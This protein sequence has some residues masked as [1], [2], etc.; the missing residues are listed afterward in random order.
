LPRFWPQKPLTLGL[1][2]SGGAHLLLEVNQG[3][4]CFD[5]YKVMVDSVRKQL[6]SDRVPYQ[7]LRAGPQGI[8]LSYALDDLPSLEKTFLTFKGMFN[9][10]YAPQTNGRGICRLSLTEAEGKALV[11]QALEKSIETIR[12]RIDETGTKEPII[13]P[14]GD[15]RILL[16]VPGA[17]KPE[18]IKSRIKTRAY[19]TFQLV[20]RTIPSEDRASVVLKPHEEVF[21][22]STKKGDKPR[23]FYIVN[24]ETIAGGEM[25]VG[26]RPGFGQY[27]DPI[28]EFQF[29][30]LGGRRFGEATSQNIGRPL[31]IVLD[32]E[33][34]SAP[35]INATIT[36]RG[37]IQG[38]FTVQEAQELSLLMR[39]GALPAPLDI[40]EERT[41]GPGLGAD[42]IARGTLATLF[43]VLA[44]MVIIFL[45]YGSFGAFAN[46]A[47][48]FNLCFLIGAMAYLGATLTLPGIAGIALTIGMAVDANVLIN[49]RIKEELL[50]QKHLETA[51]NLGYQRAFV[52]IFDSNLTTLIGAAIL[53]YFGTG[54][55]RG[56]AV[57]LSLGI[58]ISMFTAITLSRAFVRSWVA[59]VRPTKLS[60]GG[61]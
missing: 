27:N 52:T 32:G 10:T 21:P 7:F 17:E 8:S 28:V 14:Q 22:E 29:N 53:Y 46:G 23:F 48:I 60:I 13:Q 12:R 25:L 34:I 58:I 39:S 1:D 47:V 15:A 5:H 6:R 18:H 45:A 31:A 16:Q 56:F 26:A 61:V 4:L 33:V 9:I 19:L 54:P 43:A 30:A 41:V 51:I 40:L 49:E 11:R 36:D 35:N 3:K 50:R 59:A 44:V 20:K 37:I 57:T 42:S 2:L 55:V 24:K 38:N